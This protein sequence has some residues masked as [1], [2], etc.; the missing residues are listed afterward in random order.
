MLS[1]SFAPLLRPLLLLLLLMLL[2]LSARSGVDAQL[3]QEIVPFQGHSQPGYPIITLYLDLAAV[4]FVASM[5][6]AT[7]RINVTIEN[8]ALGFVKYEAGLSLRGSGSFVA[9][10]CPRRSFRF[11][12]FAP[13]CLVCTTG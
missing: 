6:R 3:N 11:R 8:N 4:A 13:R 7:I 10:T 1:N 12:L 5:D 9:T 2:L